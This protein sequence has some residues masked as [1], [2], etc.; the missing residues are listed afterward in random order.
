M[1]DAHHLVEGERV[2]VARGDL[3]VRLIARALNV[4][5]CQRK[6]DTDDVVDG[7]DIENRIGQAGIGPHLF[8]YTFG[9]GLRER[10]NVGPAK[11]VRALEAVILQAGTHP[12]AT[13]VLRDRGDR[14]WAH[15][16]A[17]QFSEA[18]VLLDLF[19]RA[20]EC[21]DFACRRKRGVV[22]FAPVHVVREA[23]FAA[24]TL[25]ETAHVRG[26]HVNDVGILAAWQRLLRFEESLIQV[27]RS[28]HIR[29]EGF[30]N[31]RVEAHRARRVHNDIKRALK[32]G[33]I[34]QVALDDVGAFL[35][36]C[37]HGIFA[38]AITP[39]GE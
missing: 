1:D 14:L 38:Y 19:R 34:C 10:V 28:T 25:G 7:D 37:A 26:G 6:D 35:E 23:A 15:L 5:S 11:R 39:R 8:A 27:L 29:G 33:E 20:R 21:I 36:G 22:L 2:R 30:V 18:Q 31:G 32:R 13:S 17:L 4:L 12:R 24:Q 3:V 9:H 16:A